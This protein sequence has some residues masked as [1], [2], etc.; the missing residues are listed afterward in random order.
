MP[1]TIGKVYLV[2]GGPGDPGLITLRGCQCLAR[3]DVVLYDYLI[4]PHILVHANPRAELVCLGRHGHGRIVP[5]D[6]INAQLVRHARAGRTV[7][8]LKG[9]DPVVFAHAAEETGALADAKIPYE[10]VPGITAALAVGSYAGIPLTHGDSASALALVTGQ[11]R[12]GKSPGLDYA[13]LA[14]FP[15]TLV[16][17][18]GV[19]TAELWSARLIAAGKPADTPAAIVRRCSQP[20]QQTIPCTLGSVAE[21]IQSR[22]L[23]P[24]ALVVV[25]PVAALAARHGWFVDRPLFGVRVLVTRAAHQAPALV[26]ALSDL[27]ADVLVQPAIEI[28]PPADWQPVDS[29]LEHLDHY[30]WLVFSSANGVRAVLDRLLKD[31]DLR[32]LGQVKLAAIG[33]GS[34]EELARYHL[35]ADVVPDEYRAESLAVALGQEA[36]A[37]KRFLLARANRGR[38][39]LAEGLVAAGARVEQIVVYTSRDVERP[40]DEILA[41]LRDGQID[42]VTATSSAIA[43]S[44]VQLFG[45]DLRNSRLATISPITSATLAELGHKTAVEADPYT[46]AGLVEAIL[47]GALGR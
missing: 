38:E 17:Y 5:Q 15:G 25:G 23:R 21:E 2:G 13:A 3:A 30:D 40:D 43:R 26:A 41:L 34:A 39:A 18:M 29:A 37:G 35:R 12:K 45:D 42:W 27:G 22:H 14:A 33:P 16:F 1:H 7:V 19:T 28:A 32:A 11:Q 47:A 31:R 24:P 9:G 4:N 10:I 6:E 20:D 44:L 8:R 36:A 46:T